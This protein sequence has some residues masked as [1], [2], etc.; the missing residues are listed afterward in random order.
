M[1]I[2]TDFV[3][4][5]SSSSFVVDLNLGFADGTT[6]TI[7]GNEWRGDY[8]CSGCSLRATDAS[9]AE[10]ISKGCGVDEELP[11]EVS[12]AIELGAGPLNLNKISGATT[13]KSLI[14]AITKPFGLSCHMETESDDDEDDEEYEEEYE[15]EEAAE[16]I[17]EIRERFNSMV[18][19][20]GSLLATHLAKKSDL[21]NAS[22]CM[23][24]SGRG[25]FLADPDEILGHIFDWKEKDE[26]IGIL[27]ADDETEIVEKLHA[28]KCLKN[29]TEDAL[30]A[31]V[32]FWKNCDCTPETCN[33]TQT[34]TPDRKIDL[35]IDWEDI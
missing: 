5:S 31:L 9:G 2:R 1:K 35:K 29:F 4:N 26:V 24:F 6:M 34:L 19:D 23:E 28:L 11:W 3:T 15:D 8:S 27:S 30:R 25:E 22:V 13:L 32:V 12:E 14:S 7:N 21:K 17:E 18:D 16:I 10:I 20:C 33:I